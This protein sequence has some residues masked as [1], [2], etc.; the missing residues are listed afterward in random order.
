MKDVKIFNFSKATDTAFV[1]T[2][3]FRARDVNVP[4]YISRSWESGPHLAV[5]F[6]GSAEDA[7][8]R[9]FAAQIR[10][11]AEAIQLNPD[12]ELQVREQY[13][14]M[15]N[16][17][18]VLEKKD[19]P[20]MMADHGSVK[21]E[22]NRFDYHNPTLTR[23]IHQMRFELQ[24]VLEE[25]FFRLHEDGEAMPALMPLLFHHVSE[26]YRDE[27]RNKGYFSFISHVQGFLELSEK[28][29]LP[30]TEAD[31][32]KRFRTHEHD[33]GALDAQGDPHIERWKEVWGKI[34]DS[35]KAEIHRNLDES[36][37][38][39]I[40]KSVADLDT[41]FQNDFHQ[42]FVRYFRQTG[43]LADMDATAYRFI[44]NVLYLSLPFLKVSALKKQQFIYMAYRYTETKNARTWREEIG[45]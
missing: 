18:A 10:R 14:K 3:I 15:V 12:D 44:V 31:F 16:R 7:V 32:E 34:S 6:D 17:I 29:N 2:V 13:R 9:Q 43:F 37:L 4:Y 23:I 33:I 27:G 42:Q 36:Y 11:E 19:V 45:V 24:P 41:G 35:Y 28:Q 20:E 26:T 1:R 30:Y 5:T 39:T 22:A 40:R 38:D 25:V 21:V 8:I